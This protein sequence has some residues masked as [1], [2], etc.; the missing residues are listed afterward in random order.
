MSRAF[1]KTRLALLLLLA[2][3]LASVPVAQADSRPTVGILR[4]GMYPTT[5]WM[6]GAI[7]DLLRLH[8]WINEDERAALRNGDDMENENL[9]IFWGDA[10]YDFNYASILIDEALDQ[11]PD[12][13][14]TFSTPLTQMAVSQ[15]LLLEAPPALI[16]ADVF[17]AVE[18]GLMSASCLKP[19]HVSGVEAIIDYEAFVSLILLQQPELASIGLLRHPADASGA[20]GAAR[21]EA[22]AE[23]LGIAVKS[24]PVL[25]LADLK[26]AVESLLGKGVDAIVMPYDLSL[27]Q[28]VSFVAEYAN[29][30]QRPVY[31]ASLVSVYGGALMSAGPFLF[32]EQG[33]QAGR[34]L[35]ASLNG[36][37]DIARSAVYAHDNLAV[38]ANFDAAAALDMELTAD[39]LAAA[40]VTI[41]DG[42]TLMEP[43]WGLMTQQRAQLLPADAQREADRAFL[44]GLECTE[45][46]IAEQRAALA[47]G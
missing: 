35:I 34:L 25:S 2:L 22:I 37:L 5:F 10:G 39:M 3:L 40:D 31:Q 27:G 29:Q 11:E 44:A 38:A 23:S 6:E 8:G 36:E 26:V 24:A 47:G 12:A 32:Y 13:L 42:E 28:A 17:N 46:L 21:I 20:Y 41:R 9:R 19:A 33:L 1:P 15:T 45:A 14:V 7:L 30:H 43:A 16:F 4:F 18:A